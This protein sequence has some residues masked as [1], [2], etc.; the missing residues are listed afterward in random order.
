MRYQLSLAFV[1]GHGKTQSNWKLPPFELAWISWIRGNQIHPRNVSY[2][3]HV[4]LWLQYDFRSIHWRISMCHRID[5]ELGLYSA[6]TLPMLQ[7]L[8]YVYGLEFRTL[9]IAQELSD[10]PFKGDFTIGIRWTC[11]VRAIVFNMVS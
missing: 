1:D 2:L 7:L 9:Y 11:K 10:K 8:R 4:S 5:H 3:Q 6:V